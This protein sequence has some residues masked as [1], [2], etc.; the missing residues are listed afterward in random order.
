MHKVRGKQVNL[1][2]GKEAGMDGLVKCAMVLF[3]GVEALVDY[4]RR[5][6]SLWV[7]VIALALGLLA[8]MFFW[9]L[10]L[11]EILACMLP[12]LL[13]VGMG[14]CPSAVIGTG[15]GV[16]LMVVG[17][18]CGLAICVELLF[19]GC[20]TSAL[21]GLCLLALGKINRR[22]Q[23]PMVPFLLAGFVEVMIWR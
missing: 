13:V 5:S 15:D 12:G 11:S 6:L 17:A 2:G 3:L 1:K 19:A 22:T 16:I 21:F 14:L 18:W 10:P 7:L 23:L 20:F 9:R 8:D 4:R